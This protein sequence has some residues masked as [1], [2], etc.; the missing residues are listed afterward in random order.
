LGGGWPKET[1]GTIPLGEGG[2]ASPPIAEVVITSR[3]TYR[4]PFVAALAGLALLLGGCILAPDE[5]LETHMQG[6]AP[7]NAEQMQCGWEKSW[8]NGDSTSSYECVYA[9]SRDAVSVGKEL[10]V[11]AGMEGFDLWCDAARHR[12]EIGGVNGRKLLT[13]EILERG[14]VSARTIAAG[15]DI[16]RGHVLIDISLVKQEKAGRAAGRRCIP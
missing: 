1:I 4:L 5:E 11:N 10:L 3:H 12:L 16:P 8:I 6:I 15:T 14:F 2:A 13:I 7:A 9:A